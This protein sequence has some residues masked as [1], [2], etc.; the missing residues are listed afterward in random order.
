MCVAAWTAFV[1]FKRWDPSSKS[2]KVYVF[3][4]IRLLG[5]RSLRRGLLPNFATI[6]A[7]RIP[8]NKRRNILP[9]SLEP[10]TFASANGRSCGFDP[11]SVYGQERQYLLQ[12]PDFSQHARCRILQEANDTGPCPYTLSYCRSSGFD[13]S[14]KRQPTQ[15]RR[16]HVRRQRG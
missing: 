11:S 2:Y 1:S 4:T 10:D 7:C 16:P 5:G 9:T 14:Q 15:L 8:Q 13:D 12:P 6:T 3:E